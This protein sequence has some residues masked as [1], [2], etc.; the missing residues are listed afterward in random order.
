M[1]FIETYFMVILSLRT[2]NKD[3]TQLLKDNILSIYSLLLSITRI[4][5]EIILFL[6]K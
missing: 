4:L 1:Y 3:N 5:K 6:D 2:I